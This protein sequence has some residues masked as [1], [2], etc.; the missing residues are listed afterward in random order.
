[1]DL[2]KL[3]QAV[4]AQ[5]SCVRKLS[6]AVSA[7]FAVGVFENFRNGWSLPESI[8]TLAG[9]AFIGVL[10]GTVLLGA[11]WQF[12]RD[13]RAKAEGRNNF[14]QSTVVYIGLVFLTLIVIAM[15]CWLLLVSIRR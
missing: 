8:Y 14:V 7:G 5:R 9:A 12:D 13:E 4:A 6:I 1:M 15:L 10:G 2:K 11:D 3:D